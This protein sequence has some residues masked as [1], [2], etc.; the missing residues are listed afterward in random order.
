V[1]A[2][3][4]RVSVAAWLMVQNATYRFNTTSA[5]PQSDCDVI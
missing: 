2:W 1:Y 4:N 3:I 5:G